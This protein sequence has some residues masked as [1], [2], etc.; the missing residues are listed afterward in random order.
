MQN[1]RQNYASLQ[2]VAA[3]VD[4]EPTVIVHTAETSRTRWN[5]IE[6]LDA[7]LRK[8]YEYHQ[9][10][11]FVCILLQ[12]IFDIIQFLFI[13][14][15]SLFL[16]YGVDYPILFKDKPLMNNATKVTINDVVLPLH[17]MLNRIGFWVWLIL[18]I[19][20][21]YG[22]GKVIRATLHAKH[23]Y[24]MKQFY[25]TALKIDDKNLDNLTWHDVQQKVITVQTELSMC[26]H[27]RELTELDIYHRILRQRNYFIAM[28]N[29][30]LL[31]PRM[32]LPLIGEV[33]YWTQGLQFN[34][35]MLLFQSPWGPF[36]DSWHLRDEY[37]KLSLRQDLAAKLR[38]S[39]LWLAFI[40]LIFSPLI[41]M[42][43][44]IYI[45]FENAEVV[46]REPN[47]LS[48]RHW[49][50]YGRFYL[51]HFNELD[52]ELNTRLMRAHRLATRY[53]AAFNDPVVAVI[54]RYI[55]FMAGAI[56]TVIIALTIYDEDVIVVEHLLTV[57]SV[58]G[59]IVA[60]CR[61]LIPDETIPWCPDTLLSNVLAHTHYLPAGWKGQAHTTKVRTEF[62]QLFQLRSSGILEEL[63]SPILTPFLLM[64]Y[65]APKSLDIVDF[66]H[67]F[68]VSVTGVGDVCSFAQMDIRK[69]GNPEWHDTRR[70]VQQSDQ[71]TQGEDG[72]VELSLIHFTHTNPSWKPPIEVLPFVESVHLEGS[73]LANSMTNP[74]VNQNDRLDDSSLRFS[75]RLESDPMSS[76]VHRSRL[77]G[78]NETSARDMSYSARYLHDR[79]S[80]LFENS[81]VVRRSVQ[82]DTPLLH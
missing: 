57:V 48:V 24:D 19:A 58:L 32:K 37:K 31:P 20:L 61:T 35:R 14:F 65:V 64:M 13:I 53:L 16:V 42:W 38:N 74:F 45:V 2:E 63:L 4:D 44:L 72:K 8:V 26:V 49:S 9:G 69:H 56:L 52:H 23:F 68:T 60:I 80:R 18:V 70:T 81:Y 7:F 75:S 47:H 11:G 73:V 78:P 54:A 15:F 59:A 43:Q 3:E 77:E 25:N 50:P 29:K 12:E 10:H 6:D 34:V 82:E 17:Q 33:V 40:N 66:F 67:N 22:L 21:F 36:K 30:N 51:S 27:K 55:G 28:V 5:H 71:Y 79:H 76:S 41:F 1:S 62:Q 39:I 46:R